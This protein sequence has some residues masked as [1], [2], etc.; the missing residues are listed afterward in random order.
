MQS[1]RR[2]ILASPPVI[3][4]YLNVLLGT[5]KLLVVLV[6]QTLALLA[7]QCEMEIALRAMTTIHAPHSTA[8]PIRSVI[9]VVLYFDCMF[10]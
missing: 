1:M 2:P 7:Q 10:S 4:M 8:M 3:L 9:V 6:L 5:S